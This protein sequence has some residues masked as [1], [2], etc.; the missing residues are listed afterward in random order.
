MIYKEISNLFYL[1]QSGKTTLSNYL[2]DATEAS[3]E[4]YRPT[5]VVRILEFEQVM[6]F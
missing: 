6:L 1:K 3:G 5:H 2:S 4:E